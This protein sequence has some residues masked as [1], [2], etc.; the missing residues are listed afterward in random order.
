MYTQTRMRWYCHFKTTK[1]AKNEEKKRKW[2]EKIKKTK[3]KNNKINVN[4]R[5]FG[6]KIENTTKDIKSDHITDS[7]LN[8]SHPHTSRHVRMSE[9]SYKYTQLSHYSYERTHTMYTN[10]RFNTEQF[11]AIWQRFHLKRRKNNEKISKKFLWFSTDRALWC[12]GY[13]R[14]TV[15]T[16]YIRKINRQHQFH[17]ITA[18]NGYS[19]YFIWANN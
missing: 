14:G 7:R 9:F 13:G 16:F 6:E 12:M 15:Y 4:E 11:S 17:Y 19:V 1:N 2:N 8:I 5:K 18:K 3:R 10:R